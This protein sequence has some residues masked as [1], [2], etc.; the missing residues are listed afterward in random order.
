MA[1]PNTPAHVS[2]THR[3]PA[4][5]AP[6]LDAVV[7]GAEEPLTVIN[8]STRWG[9]WALMLGFGG[10]LAWASF[11]PLDEGV[12]TTALVSIDTKRKAVQHL[13]GGIITQVL[14][15]EGDF[16][17]E[18]QVVARLD[19]AATLASY[20]A[21]RHRYLGLRATQS[22]LTAEQAGQS[23]IVFHPD[24]KKA[25][26][27]DLHVQQLVLT[28]QQLAS[29]RRAA[30]QADLQGIQESIQGQ[31]AML[32][33]YQQML[34]NKRQQLSLLNE[35]LSSTTALVKEGFL[36]RPRQL[37][38]ERQ[39]AG[40]RSELAEL[41]GNTIR[42]KRSIAELR[43]RLV[44]RQQEYRKEVESQLAE[45]EREVQA[46]A[47]KLRAA[48]DDL[49]R[50]DIKSPAA[51][52]VVGLAFQTVGGVVAPGQ[53]LM[54]IVPP[55]EALL[56]EAQVHPHLIDRVRE[57]L[58]V[59]VR[60]S[61]FAH[62]PQLVVQGRVVSVSADNLTDPKSGN[63]YY[64][65][66]VAVTPDGMVTLGKREM[67]PGMPAEVVFKTGERSLLTYLLQPLVRRVAA[68]MKE[69]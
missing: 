23:S 53:K 40:I 14:V 7:H 63:A 21:I 5:S 22:R 38:Q 44:N 8:R 54:D 62:T 9:F 52:Q 36:A 57:G 49:G 31:Q 61:A 67:R 4:T 50:V 33:A 41:Q 58:A 43:Q 68:S 47:D 26:D 48:Q 24:V 27:S 29:S 32:T 55:D 1:S 18:G 15:G 64:L 69:E 17:K 13:T 60:F 6:Y 11:A 19:E 51:G 66:R 3:M 56:L 20:Q 42:S 65:A 30:L 2:I 25:A 28:Q 37:D 35:D 46:D 45:I 12:P 16:V 10:F 34:P 39:L 59:D